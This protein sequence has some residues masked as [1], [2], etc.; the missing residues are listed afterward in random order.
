MML[1]PEAD[2]EEP[3]D[4]WYLD[5]VL[6]ANHGI[7]PLDADGMTLSEIALALEEPRRGGGNMSEQEIQGR[8]DR[9]RRL[10]PREKLLQG[11]DL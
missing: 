10:T 11:K 7:T 8:I 2:R 9:W 4:W 3:I 6:L 1:L 5:Q